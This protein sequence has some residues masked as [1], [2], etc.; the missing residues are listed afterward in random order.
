MANLFTDT[1]QVNDAVPPLQE[2]LQIN[3]NHAE[4]NWEMS[5]A[6]RFGGLLAESVAS[7]ERAR[8][9]DP[10]V[11]L[12]S[13]AINAYLYLCRYDDFLAR[14]PTE[15][16]SAYVCAAGTGK[17]RRRRFLV[18]H[19]CSGIRYWSR[20]EPRFGRSHARQHDPHP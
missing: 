17:K 8:R 13:S 1:G 10:S 16:A 5:Y 9:L 2:A 19:T 20:C 14:L 4:A 6:Y 3:P 11:K 18:I 12:N 7:A 15:G